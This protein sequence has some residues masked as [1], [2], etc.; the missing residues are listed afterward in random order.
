[1]DGL[2]FVVCVVLGF[3]FWGQGLYMQAEQ[4]EEMLFFSQLS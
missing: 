1:M 4:G 3:F 2:G